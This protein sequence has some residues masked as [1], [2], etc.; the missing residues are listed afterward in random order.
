MAEYRNLHVIPLSLFI[1]MP[2]TFVITYF[3]AVFWDHVHPTL[4][5]ISETGA[6]SPESCIFAQ[7][8]NIAALLLLCW[9][10]IRHRQISKFSELQPENRVSNTANN[11]AT[12]FGIIGCIGL[13]V[14]ANFQESR[15]VGIHMIGAMTCFAATNIYFC[16]QTVFSC[17]LRPYINSLRMIYIRAVINFLSVAFTVSTVLPGSISMQ[18]FN[19]TDYK[20]WLPSDGGWHWHMTSVISEYFLTLSFCAYLLT[21]VHEFRRIHFYSP[22]IE[23]NLE[24]KSKDTVSKKNLEVN[25]STDSNGYK[26]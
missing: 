5:Y 11:L 21:F 20:K 12:I 19:G 26:S 6:F 13:D 18:Q 17:N 25:L 16:M 8:L 9:V 1:L 2:V 24:M 3:I 10:Y 4:P 14:V 22:E 15:S 23:L 7:F